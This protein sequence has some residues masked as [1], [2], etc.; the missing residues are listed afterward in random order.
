MTCIIQIVVGI[1]IGA[2]GFHHISENP[3]PGISA[4][5][6]AGFLV[7]TGLEK[8]LTRQRQKPEIGSS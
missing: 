2:A 7:M 4:L 1:L 3:A 8:L 6:L 5:F